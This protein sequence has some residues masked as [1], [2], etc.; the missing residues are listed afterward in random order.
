M[1]DKPLDIEKLISTFEGN[2]GK[3]QEALDHK[4]KTTDG[5]IAALTE[6]VITL[7]NAAPTDVRLRAGAQIRETLKN[8]VGTNEAAETFRLWEEGIK[9]SILLP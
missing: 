2:L 5:Q 3:V 9:R 1:P 6:V 7:L 8:S 4:F